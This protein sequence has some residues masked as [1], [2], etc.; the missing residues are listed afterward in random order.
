[1]KSV[2]QNILI[3]IGLYIILSSGIVNFFAQKSVFIFAV[4]SVFVMLILAYVLLNLRK[5]KIGGN[6]D[7]K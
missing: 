4:A 2:V 3:F 1:M 5:D 6:K 7:E